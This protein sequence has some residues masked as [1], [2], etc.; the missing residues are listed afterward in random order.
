MADEQEQKTDSENTSTQQNEGNQDVTMS[1]D[2]LNNLI[3]GK[4]AKGAESATKEL[5]TGLGVDSVDD[6]KNL[7]EAK[8]TADEANKS[9]LEKLQEQLANANTKNE[10]LST[11]LT[12]TKKSAKL[13]RLALENGIE[14]VEY[15][16]F[17][18]NK[19]SQVEG[20]DEKVFINGLKESNA[21]AFKQPNKMDNSSNN[22]NKPT[23][24]K[25]KIKGLSMKQLKALQNSL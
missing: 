12:S 25:D 20:F 8:K 1:Q 9:E 15:L 7:I 14:D 18:Y 10:E 22:N 6:I 13:N 11:N 17:K 16:E 21:N 5:L 3:N 23:E 24:L 2:K 4:Y 19:A